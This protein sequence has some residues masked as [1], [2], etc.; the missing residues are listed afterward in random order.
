MFKIRLLQSCDEVNDIPNHRKRDHFPDVR[1]MIYG[2][3]MLK[4]RLLR[5]REEVVDVPNHRKK[6]SFS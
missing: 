1:K 4:I 5:R 3:K 6:G 2:C